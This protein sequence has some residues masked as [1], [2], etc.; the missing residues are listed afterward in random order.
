MEAV[1]RNSM[2]MLWLLPQYIVITAGE[3]MLA[4]TGI[5]FSYS[6]SPLSMKSV[7]Q[8]SWLLTIAF[9]QFFVVLIELMNIFK[10]QVRL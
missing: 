6:Q 3:V 10:K 8:A 2:H 1:T 5:E 9:G 7:L 4:V